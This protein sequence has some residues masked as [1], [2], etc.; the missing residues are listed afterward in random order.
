MATPYPIS[1]II[2]LGKVCSPLSQ[3]NVLKNNAFKYG[4][5]NYQ[6]PILIYL[7]TKTLEYDYSVRPLS[8][9]TDTIANYLYALC[10]PFIGQAFI[11]LGQGQG[12]IIIDPGS[13]QPINLRWVTF[14]FTVGGVGSLIDEGESS[15]VVDLTNILFD[16]V[17]FGYSNSSPLPRT[18]TVP[19]GGQTY[20]PT[21]TVNN[22]LIQLNYTVTNGE[23]Y[24]LSFGRATAGSTFNPGAQQLP[25]PYLRGKYLTN[26]GSNLSWDDP[27]VEITSAN[28]E[29][30]GITYI[31]TNL[32]IHTYSVFLNDINRFL[33]SGIE[34]EPILSGGFTILLDGFDANT[35]DYVLK[36]FNTGA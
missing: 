27:L 23:Q 12:G 18:N 30:D 11:A 2:Q 7:V 1:T 32:A 34:Y 13:G 26:D 4:F 8:L 33:I 17:A 20:M 22:V 29:G 9:S 15:F 36:I 6:Q 31:N 16:S 28:F 14:S 35:N 25:V 21:Y 10:E 5:F 24:T 3:I 19:I